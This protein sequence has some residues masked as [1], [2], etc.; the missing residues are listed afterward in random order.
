MH[1]FKMPPFCHFDL[2]EMEPQ[3][4]LREKPIYVYIDVTLI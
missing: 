4:L 3:F 2:T 1:L